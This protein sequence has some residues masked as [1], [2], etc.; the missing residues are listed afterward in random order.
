MRTIFGIVVGFLLAIGAAYVHDYSV[1]Q[2]SQLQIVNW[3][4]LGNVA[5]NETAAVRKLWD[6]TIGKPKPA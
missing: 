4:V 1:S 3:D 5:R 2:G 6:D